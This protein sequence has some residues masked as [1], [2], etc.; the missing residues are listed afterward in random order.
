MHHL[1]SCSFEKRLKAFLMTSRLR[2]VKVLRKKHL[3]QVMDGFIT[4][5]NCITSVSSESASKD[6]AVAEKFPKT[7]EE[8]IDKEG[9][10]PQQIFNI[11]KA[12]LFRKKCHKKRILAITR[13]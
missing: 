3:L 2:L 10:T 4:S 7:L 12:G 1:A 5:K 9:Y 11:D 8:I 6:K 13:R